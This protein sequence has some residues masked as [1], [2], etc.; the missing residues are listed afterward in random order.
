VHKNGLRRVMELRPLRH[1][2]DILKRRR[3]SRNYLRRHLPP[4]QL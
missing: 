2:Y 1:L 3:L 4:K